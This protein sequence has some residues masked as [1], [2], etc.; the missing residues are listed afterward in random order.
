ME[1]YSALA[2]ANYFLS[3]YRDT[4]I[5]P[6]KIQKLTYIAHG[7]HLAFMDKPLVCDED[8]EAWRYGPVFPSVYHEFKYRG[9]LP[10]IELG[11]DFKLNDKGKFVR[12]VPKIKED[13]VTTK[14]LLNKVWEIYGTW[15][16]TQLSQLCHQP[17][18]PWEKTWKRS[19]GT[20]NTNILDAV[21][22]EHY[23]EK[24]KQNK[25]KN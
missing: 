9:G 20:R 6:L 24:I 13:D 4:G 22:K 25:R 3:N 15:S 1:G 19:R 23:L 18:T 2:V 10:I 12:E 8:P 7:W 11:T 14:R 17:G 16:G 21:I 5:S